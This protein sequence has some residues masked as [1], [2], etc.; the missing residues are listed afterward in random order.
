MPPDREIAQDPWE[1]QL[2]E[3][4]ANVLLALRPTLLDSS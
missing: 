3:S 4:V 2:N 1:L